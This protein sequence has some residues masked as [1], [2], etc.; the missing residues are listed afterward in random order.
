[1]DAKALSHA[2]YLDILFDNRNKQYGSYELRRNYDK[3]AKTSLLT[4]LAVCAAISA[5]AFVNSNKPDVAITEP[6]VVPT[7]MTEIVYEKKPLEIE[8][9]KPIAPPAVTPTVANTVPKVV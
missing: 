7:K 8:K 6:K 3:R 5:Y 1:M 2:D 9:P 4:I